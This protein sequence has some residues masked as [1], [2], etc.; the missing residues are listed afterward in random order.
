MDQ[1]FPHSR[2]SRV[3]AQPVTAATKRAHHARLQRLLT[4]IAAYLLVLLPMQVMAQGL[5]K[6]KGII[7]RVTSDIYSMVTAIAVLIL[8]AMGIAYA[9]KWMSLEGFMRWLIGC[10]IVGSASEIARMIFN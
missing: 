8:I 5:S 3:H 4:T 9:A 10:V 7:E 6:G 1:I 2:N